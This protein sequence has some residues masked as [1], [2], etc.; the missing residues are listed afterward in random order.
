M[1]ALYFLSGGGVVEKRVFRCL[2]CD[3]V[4]DER[5]TLNVHYLE[6]HPS[7]FSSEE[8]LMAAA[9]RTHAVPGGGSSPSL[10]DA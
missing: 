3:G 8:L 10:A 1:M 4:F 9:R 6:V 2:F 5:K 7:A